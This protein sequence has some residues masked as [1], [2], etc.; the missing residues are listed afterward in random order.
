MTWRADMSDAPESA[1]TDDAV[2][3]ETRAAAKWLMA[4]FAAVGAILVGGIGL[5]ALGSLDGERLTVAIVGAIVAGLGVIVAVSLTTDVLTPDP[6]TIAGLA[7]LASSADPS[8]DELR[9]LEYIESDPSLLQGIIDRDALKPDQQLLVEA[10][11]AY[12][13]AVD[14]RFRTADEYWRTAAQLGA[15]DPTT[16]TARQV[17]D[18]ASNKASTMHDTVKR[19]ERIATGQQT[20]IAFRSIRAVLAVVAVFIALGIGAFAAA[21]NPPDPATADLGGANL[22]DVDLSGASLRGADLSDMSLRDTNFEGTNLDDANI[23]DTKWTNVT[24]PDG[25]NSHNAGDTCEGHLEPDFKPDP[26][27]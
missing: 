2:T 3:Q 23:E 14:D 12:G 19:L 9:L 15:D 10:N 21:S 7:R 8:P 22:T 17:A 1:P 25:T 5:N 24:C 20:V 13:A 6:V 18:I 27:R 11:L 4:A 26:L 16:K